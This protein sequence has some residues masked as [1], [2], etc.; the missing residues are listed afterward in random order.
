IFVVTSDT[1]T[2]RLETNPVT[3]VGA[4][5]DRHADGDNAIL[6]IDGGLD[7]NSSPGV[8]FTDPGS[9]AYGFEAFDSSS[10]GFFAANGEGLY[11]Q[12]VD[13]S[14]LAEGIHFVNSR[15]FRHRDPSTNTNDDPGL[16]GDG[17]PAVFMDFREAIYVDRLPPESG[18]VSFE[19]YGQDY[20]RDL[21][22]GSLDK[23]ADQIHVFLNM[24]A[25]V[26]DAELRTMAL[27]GQ[28][29]AGYYDRDQFIYGFGDVKEGNQ[30]VTLVTFEVT[31]NWNV[32]RFPGIY[33]ETSRGLGIGDT[34][35]N[36]AF[37]VADVSIF[38]NVLFSNNDLFNPAA[39]ATGDGLVDNRDLFEVGAILFNAGVDQATWDAF[40]LMLEQ[41]ADTNRDG[42]TDSLDIDHLY[43]NLG[44]DDWWFDMN[45]DGMVD[46]SDVTTLVEDFFQSLFGDANL[47]G[48]VDVSDF[49]AWNANKFTTGSGWAGGDFNGDDVTDISDFNIW[50]SNKFQSGNP[51]YANRPSV[52]PEPPTQAAFA[53]L[54][55][56]FIFRRG[57]KEDSQISRSF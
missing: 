6:R 17:G 49:N 43:A 39:D 29:T 40:D 31:G 36:N 20:E 45:G 34:N 19:P 44:S 54:M 24:P 16:F 33:T 42:T 51:F 57:R 9:V 18:V 25:N 53:L 41:R 2:V 3:L 30:V 7:I 28:G 11:E 10:P 50:N 23:T 26:T 27:N 38:R 48:T 1:M 47:D 15:A 21:V 35:F 52:V 37:S 12:Q 14:Q 13:V 55:C 46:D 32:Q 8:D 4:I 5:R 22:A 56:V